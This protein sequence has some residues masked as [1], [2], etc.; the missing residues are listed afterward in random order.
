MKKNNQFILLCFTLVLAF[1]TL[2]LGAY[3]R[4]TNAGLGCPDWPGCYGQWV[5]PDVA[6]QSSAQDL[7]PT[8]PIESTKAWTEMAHRYLVGGLAC[9]V[10]IL[11]ALTFMSPKK[12]H[13]SKPL[14]ALLALLFFFQATLGKWTVTLKLLPIVVMG[15]LLGGISIFS[16]LACLALTHEK[17]IKVEKKG[18]FAILGAVIVLFCQIALGGWVSSNYAGLACVGFPS[19]NGMLWPSL[20][21]SGGFHLLSPLGLNYQGGILNASA[22]VT[23]QWIHRVG[24]LITVFYLFGLWIMIY[25]SGHR[26]KLLILCTIACVLVLLQITLGM[27]NVIYLLPIT[28]AVAHHAV[29]VLLMATAWMMFYLTRSHHE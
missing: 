12:T 16:I 6:N 21:F 11:V 1:C 18:L 22:R 24:A 19:C 26:N 29:A 2:S 9:C 5:L 25:R 13:F 8:Q 23:I 10:F 4:L 28:V 17:K 27:M 15:H 20:D 14:M 3:T 7:Y